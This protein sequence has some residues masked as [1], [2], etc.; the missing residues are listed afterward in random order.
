MINLVKNELIKIF[1]KKGLYIYGIIIIFIMAF[2][3]VVEK[4]RVFDNSFTYYNTSEERLSK[5]DL[6][7]SE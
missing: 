5:Y 7:N 3:L 6:N 2:N 1:S 4:T